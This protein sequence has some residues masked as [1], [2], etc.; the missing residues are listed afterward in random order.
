MRLTRR[1]AWVITIAF[2][3]LFV[4]VSYLESVGT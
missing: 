1:G 3:S 2:M 4:A